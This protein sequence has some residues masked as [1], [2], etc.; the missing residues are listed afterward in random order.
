[1]VGAPVGAVSA[2]AWF[3][4]G[5][6]GSLRFWRRAQRCIRIV[7][8]VGHHKASHSRGVVREYTRQANHSSRYFEPFAFVMHTLTGAAGTEQT[9]SAIS[10]RVGGLSI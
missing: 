4:L 2:L 1:M 7:D 6:R 3:W 10:F 9:P 5:R 8:Y